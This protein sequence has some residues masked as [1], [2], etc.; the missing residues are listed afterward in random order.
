MS[1][2]AGK[3]FYKFKFHINGSEWVYNKELAKI[4]DETGHYN[5]SLHVPVIEIP[6]IDIPSQPPVNAHLIAESVLV[7]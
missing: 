5:N 6:Q 7:E 1:T 4:K 3:S 2:I